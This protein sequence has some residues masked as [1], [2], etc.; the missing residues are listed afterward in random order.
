M[1]IGE[2]DGAAYSLTNIGD[3]YRFQHDPDSALLYYTEALRLRNE[4]SDLRGI[5]FSLNNIATT[6]FDRGQYASA[7]AYADSS[8]AICQ[9]KGFMEGTSLNAKLLS[10]LY[11]QEGNGMRALEMFKLHVQMKDS[12]KNEATQKATVEQQTR[13]AFEKAQLVKEHEAAE[14]ARIAAAKTRRR[15]NM[16]YSIIF[17]AI[18][19]FFGVIISLGYVRFSPKL[20]EGLIF[21]AFLMLFEF[22]LVFIDPYLGQYTHDVPLYKLIA[23]ACVA[24]LIFPAHSFLENRLKRQVLQ[25][26]S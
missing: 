5:A 17:L 8:L 9:E 24:L 1:E 22:V 6:E 19:V 26:G 10:K 12:L 14:M 18:L 15:N 20:A 3:I 25:E 11:E 23:N 13:Y 21:F 7:K 4:I 16:Q 2:K